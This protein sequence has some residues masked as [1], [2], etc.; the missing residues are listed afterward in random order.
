MYN[1]LLSVAVFFAVMTTYP[2]FA[3][4]GAGCAEDCTSCHSLAKEEADKLLQADKFQAKTVDIRQSP[5]KG[6]W[7]IELTQ[8]GKNFIIYMDYAK[9]HL[10]D[11]R[12]TTL[13]T[14]GKSRPLRKI[15]ISQ[16]PLDNAII[17]GS[18][19]AKHK[20]IVFDDPDCPVCR[21]FHKDMKKIVK[22]DKNIAFYIKLF[23]L[24]IH[25][26][27]YKKSMAIACAKS[28]ALLDDAMEG[29]EIPPA[30]C[31][32]NDIKNNL[33]LAKKLKIGAT[34]TI[35]LPDG[36]VIPGRPTTKKLLQEIYTPTVT[37]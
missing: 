4:Q 35:I 9:K 7:E 5:V 27:A 1:F 3:F 6:L 14:I 13:D 37:D 11:A 12:F 22:T 26:N 25:P 23:P 30:T 10:V 33:A 36:R 21:E 34:P 18:K 15:D 8:K 29:K 31:K 32:T 20:I 24:A 19:K 17:I 2:A 28:L 16:V